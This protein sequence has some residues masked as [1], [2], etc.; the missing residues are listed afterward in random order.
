MFRRT[1]EN[2]GP[3]TSA[4]GSST[5]LEVIPDGSNVRRNDVLCR[6]DASDYEELARQQRIKVEAAETDRDRAQLDLEVAE[7]TLRE[8]RDGTRNQS[9]EQYD[10]Q[11]T[12]AKADIQR[13]SDRLAW[14]RRMAAQGYLPRGRV[15]DEEI[16]LQRSEASLAKS[17][18][19]FEN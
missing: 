19:A 9:M 13:Q 6:L 15:V 16:G 3:L 10:G 17:I 14:S 8:F 1:S 11:I 12:L 18:M 7:I 2:A 5:I 4:G